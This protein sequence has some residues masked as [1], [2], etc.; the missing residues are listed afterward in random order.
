MLIETIFRVGIKK[1]TY[2]SLRVRDL[3]VTKFSFVEVFKIKLWDRFWQYEAITL[4][5]IESKDK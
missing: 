1:K 5:K 2:K 3:V 4:S